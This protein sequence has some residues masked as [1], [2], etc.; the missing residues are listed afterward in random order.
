MP[1]PAD[2]LYV[3]LTRAEENLSVIITSCDFE[4]KTKSSPIRKAFTQALE[5]K[6]KQFDK[7]H[8]LSGDMKLPYC[9]FS[10]LARSADGEALRT[11]AEAGDL[12]P[13]NTVPFMDLDGNVCKGFEVVEMPAEKIIELY[14]GRKA[15]RTAEEAEQNL[16]RLKDKP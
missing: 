8:W 9:L 4:D 1:R 11:I 13:G 7:R 2:F 16:K 3:A 15:A 10:G 12:K 14:E 5:Y 6:D